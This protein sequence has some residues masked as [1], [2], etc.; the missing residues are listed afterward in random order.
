MT[1]IGLLD[2]NK[3]FLK[4]PSLLVLEKKPGLHKM[5]LKI[6]FV[7]KKYQKKI[8]LKKYSLKSIDF[9]FWFLKY[10]LKK[11]IGHLMLENECKI[12]VMFL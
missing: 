12:A 7:V 11:F 1:F 2:L 9:L 5:F 10:I 8:F 6:N 4:K 3:I